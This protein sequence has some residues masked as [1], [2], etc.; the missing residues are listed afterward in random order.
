MMK[1]LKEAVMILLLLG[2][3]VMFAQEEGGMLPPEVK[4]SI[5]KMVKVIIADV[6][7]IDTVANTDKWLGDQLQPKQNIEAKPVLEPG[8]M[9]V[10]PHLRA[11]Y[12]RWNMRTKQME[13]CR[14]A[15]QINEENAENIKILRTLRTRTLIDSNTRN[16]ILCKDFIQAALS[17]KYRNLI[18][19]VD[20][21]NADMGIVE[22]TLQGKEENVIVASGSCI[23]TVIM[24]D[25]ETSSRTV[26]VNA[27]GT[28]TKK[29]TYRQ[30][31]TGKVRDLQGNVLI[32]FDDVAELT[33]NQNNVVKSELANPTREL[34]KKACEKIA[35]EIG[36]YFVTQLKFAIK[37]PKG[38]DDF[39]A[40][41]ATVLL[42][43]REVD[44]D[45]PVYVIAAEHEVTAM[46]DGYKKI[47]RVISLSDTV[48]GAPKTIKLNFKKAEK[49]NIEQKNEEE[50]N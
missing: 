50:E 7:T 36:G 45:T 22:Q 27:K 19:V 39:D 17:R 38:D 40:D 32:A 23:V 18:Q 16:V 4:N 29:T 20:R 44:V 10:D 49:K 21:G 41:D 8:A 26:T 14:N 5:P 1:T 6:G 34:M 12:F 30:P 11:E 43:G 46:M 15:R 37:G 13:Y 35:D 31:Y 47:Q 33:Q 24:G 2:M 3:G 48:P 25:L 28:Q 9:A 42:D